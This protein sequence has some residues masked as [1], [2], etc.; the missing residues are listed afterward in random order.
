MKISDSNISGVILAAGASKRMGT[1]KALLE[2]KDG[3]TLLAGQAALL[4]ASDCKNVTVV[5]GAESEDILKRHEELKV[6]WA[7]ND[8]WEL[9]Q[10]S[11]LQAGLRDAL[12]DDPIGML[13]L[14]V[15]VVGVRTDTI[16]AIIET[17][18]RNPHL[19]AVVPEH[20]GRGG[21]PIYLS[22][23]FCEKL[24]ALDPQDEASRLDELI[25]REKAVM[26]LPV[27]DENVAKNVNTKED[28]KG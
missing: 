4:I 12:A 28:W 23:K 16:Q 14:P 22:R 19:S 18:L 2:F 7:V 9:G 17:A 13:V 10:F 20:E 1:P 5:I 6:K 27:N 11:S 25:H 15:D 26:P 24:I 8:N 3:T 21:H